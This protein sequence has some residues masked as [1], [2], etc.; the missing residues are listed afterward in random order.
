M[1]YRAF[2][3]LLGETSLER[4]CRFLLGGG[5]LLLMSLSF[6]LFARQP[7]HLAD[8][9][10]IDM[11]RSLVKSHVASMHVSKWRRAAVKEFQANGG[12]TR[13][14]PLREYR[15]ALILPDP[16]TPAYKAEGS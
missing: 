9:Q 12:Q 1:S 5:I 8:N 13:R 7:E 4:K 3:R 16:K 15:E 14:L 6:W 2:K 10:T 11:C